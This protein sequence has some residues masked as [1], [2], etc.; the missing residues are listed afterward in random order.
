MKS[1]FK[2]EKVKYI[3][4]GVLILLSVVSIVAI[5]YPTFVKNAKIKEI[6]ELMLEYKNS[7]NEK[8][9]IINKLKG[10]IA[11]EDEEVVKF[12]KDTKDEIE[13]LHRARTTYAMIEK[14]LEN[15]DVKYLTK[16][17]KEEYKNR[18]LEDIPE[19]HE[20]YSK[21]LK[22]IEKMEKGYV[23]GE[24]VV[25]VEYSSPH[26]KA[27]NQSLNIKLKNTSGKDIRYLAIDI[28]EYDKDGNV[29]NSEWANT[30]S[31]ILNGASVSIDTYFDYQRSDST[32][33]FRVRDVRYN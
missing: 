22:L 13:R 2:S 11:N 16:K 8:Y 33:K 24:S 29:V 7:P 4:G 26:F 3:L 25:L 1:I 15:Q 9:N 18:L 32:L 10:Y 14:K 28:L 30:S 21:A 5:E 20:Y 12:A 19:D 6:N 27:G 23:E 17:E 31:L